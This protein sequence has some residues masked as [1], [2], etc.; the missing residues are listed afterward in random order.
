MKVEGGPGNLHEFVHFV[1]APGTGGSAATSGATEA[2]IADEV[3]EA[4]AGQAFL[5]GAQAAHL[6]ALL[7]IPLGV[8]LGRTTIFSLFLIQD[9]GILLS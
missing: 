1:R 2:W 7:A 9:Y 3:G 4:R 8:A 6:G 5:R